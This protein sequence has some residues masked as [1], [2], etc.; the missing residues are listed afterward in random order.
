MGAYFFLQIFV[1]VIIKYGII[2]YGSEIA[3]IEDRKIVKWS[4]IFCS[5]GSIIFNVGLLVEVD[6]TKIP[7]F[8]A[9]TTG[10]HQK[11]TE[12]DPEH[13]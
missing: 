6:I 11:L 1:T 7:N 5:V 10:I 8:L 3:L 4:R 2:F 9:L 13:R 12:F